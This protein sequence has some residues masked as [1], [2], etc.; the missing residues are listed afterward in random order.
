ME[1]KKQLITDYSRVDRC[2]FDII[3]MIE[4]LQNIQQKFKDYFENFDYEAMEQLLKARDKRTWIFKRYAI[5]QK[6]SL[7]G[8]KVELLASSGLIDAPDMSHLLS[9]IE[10]LGTRYSMF[11]RETPG[12]ID[13][14]HD[15]SKD[16]VFTNPFTWDTPIEQRIIEL[17]SVSADN[18]EEKDFLN[19]LEQLGELYDLFLNKY[20]MIVPAYIPPRLFR[21]VIENRRHKKI[22]SL[23][24]SALEYFKYKQQTT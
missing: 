22:Q 12:I 6:I 9:A 19:D 17:F 13:E 4:P 16:G 18:E 15:L 2:K 10:R 24:Y 5:D 11:Q 14:L 7:V 20:K 8:I 1:N 21:V 23:S 3:N